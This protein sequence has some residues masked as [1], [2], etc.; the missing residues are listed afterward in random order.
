MPR[1]YFFIPRNENP[2][3]FNENSLKSED[4]TQSVK[5]QYATDYIFAH[6]DKPVFIGDSVTFD[7]DENWEIVRADHREALI[8]IAD[9]NPVGRQKM[10]ARH[11]EQACHNHRGHAGTAEDKAA[12]G[13]S[14]AKIFPIAAPSVFAEALIEIIAD[15]VGTDNR[16][17]VGAAID[18]LADY[19]CDEFAPGSR[20]IAQLTLTIADFHDNLT[21]NDFLTAD[22]AVDKG[23]AKTAMKNRIDA[24][25]AGWQEAAITVA[26]R[27]VV[28]RLGITGALLVSGEDDYA[29]PAQVAKG[30]THKV[31]MSFLLDGGILR[32]APASHLGIFITAETADANNPILTGVLPSSATRTLEYATATGTDAVW[33]AASP[34]LA[35]SEDEV[36]VRLSRPPAPTA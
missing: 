28:T 33:S 22:R 7:E 16:D 9:A 18:E 21:A 36:F 3:I 31:P 10:M 34:T 13:V 2:F 35:T 17:A 5:D 20:T 12:A 24:L 6:T 30:A 19:A 29:D 15:K 23:R 14:L 1:T 32:F 11:L 27:A 25:I 4:W 8:Q 26:A